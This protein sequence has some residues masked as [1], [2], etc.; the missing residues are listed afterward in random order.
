[1]NFDGLE[2]SA[3]DHLPDSLKFV[4]DRDS[5]ERTHV[6]VSR[7]ACNLLKTEMTT[8]SGGVHEAEFL[9]DDLSNF[10]EDQRR[11]FTFPSYCDNAPVVHNWPHISPA[12]ALLG[13]MFLP[14]VF[15]KPCCDFPDLI[16]NAQPP[17]NAREQGGRKRNSHFDDTEGGRGR[18]DRITS[19]R[20]RNV[21]VGVLSAGTSK[22][23]Q[24]AK[25]DVLR[26]NALIKYVLEKYLQGQDS[27][28]EQGIVDRS[29]DGGRDP[30]SDLKK[31]LLESVVE[32]LIKEDNLIPNDPR[33]FVELR[34]A[35]I[36]AISGGEND[37]PEAGDDD[38][39]TKIGEF[40]GDD[41][42]ERYFATDDL[43]VMVLK[44]LFDIEDG[45][46]DTGSDSE[47]GDIEGS[48]S[49]DVSDDADRRESEDEDTDRSESNDVDDG[50]KGELVSAV[51]TLDHIEEDQTGNTNNLSIKRH[52]R[53]KRHSRRHSRDKKKASKAKRKDDKK[54]GK[55]KVNEDK[56]K[57]K[58]KSQEAKKK[59]KMHKALKVIGKITAAVVIGLS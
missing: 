13:R 25:S 58:S 41:D 14:G 6:I 42:D 3:D 24:A 5:G 57:A 20:L 17:N 54:K 55:S 32:E 39:Q 12:F 44:V 48:E 4:L 28:D 11:Q 22:E 47:D 15:S 38:D 27:K 49:S 29:Q 51:E 19:D 21:L 33:G 37:E 26:R 30:S 35:L 53:S 34:D 18:Q 50:N 45:R 23:P 59:H 7:D 43:K 10:A 2:P 8:S 46:D 1:M 52:R 40:G 16:D 56:S 9:L 31:A 36:E